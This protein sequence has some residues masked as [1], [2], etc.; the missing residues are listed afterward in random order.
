MNCVY[1]R[2]R[3]RDTHTCELGFGTRPRDPGSVEGD[4]PL[5]ATLPRYWTSLITGAFGFS[6]RLRPSVLRGST[7]RTP[8]SFILRWV[9]RCLPSRK[10][11][12]LS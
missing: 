5:K 10:L 9:V 7:N 2:L 6:R 8:I 4:F 12:L 11:S 1:R 3:L